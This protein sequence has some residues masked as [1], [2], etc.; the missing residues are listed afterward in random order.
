MDFKS[1]INKEKIRE[2][3]EF[4]IRCTH[5][6]KGC[7]WVG[8]LEEIKQHLE[9]NR[10]CGY[11]VVKCTNINPDL[12]LDIYGRHITCGME[13]ERK[14]LADHQKNECKYRQYEC[15]YCGHV[16]T[17]DAIAGTGRNRVFSLS[18]GRFKNHYDRCGQFP[19]ECPNKCGEKEIKRKDMEGHRKT[20][21]LEPLDCPFKSVGCKDEISRKDM[22]HHTQKS[23]QSHLLLVVRSHQELA[24]KNDNLVRKNEE[25]TKKMEKSNNEFSARL[26]KLERRQRYNRR[27][28]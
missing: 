6:E 2:I 9:G 16:A 12:G 28:D 17:Y 24:W 15:K 8:K 19:L 25:L 14:Y 7:D 11:A 3:N 4:P 5:R 21:P 23:V 20:C 27:H 26:E 22:E 13:I 1:F 18:P 10:G